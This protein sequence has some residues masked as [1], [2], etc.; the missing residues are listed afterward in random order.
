MRGRNLFFQVVL[1]ILGIDI[2]P[3][4]EHITDEGGTDETFPLLPRRI[5]SR[6]TN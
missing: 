1:K 2:D 6:W 3:F 4:G 5:L